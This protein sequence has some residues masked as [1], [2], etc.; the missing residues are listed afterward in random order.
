M[1][2][3][4]K[5]MA[6][7]Y[8]VSIYII[9]SISAWKKRIDGP[10]KLEKAIQAKNTTDIFLDPIVD[11]LIKEESQII[12]QGEKNEELSD[13][14]KITDIQNDIASSEEL[15]VDFIRELAAGYN[16][17]DNMARESFLIDFY[18]C[19]PE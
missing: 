8:N 3:R 15:D 11:S 13:N 5:E 6:K 16:L 10:L 1:K 14:S 7:K 18:D 9:S 17:N 12:I 4:R 19:Y 2:E